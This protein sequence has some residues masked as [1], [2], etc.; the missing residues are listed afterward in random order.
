MSPVLTGFAS[1]NGLLQLQKLQRFSRILAQNY[2]RAIPLPPPGWKKPPHANPGFLLTDRACPTKKMPESEIRKDRIT[3]FATTILSLPL[4]HCVLESLCYAFISLSFTQ[5]GMSPA[6][7]LRAWI[8][9]TLLSF[10][11]YGGSLPCTRCNCTLLHSGGTLPAC[12]PNCSKW[13]AVLLLPAD[14]NSHF[15]ASLPC[16]RLQFRRGFCKQTIIQFQFYNVSGCSR[17]RSSG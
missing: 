5:Y 3:Y 13:A 4:C 17:A 16:S 8:V 9:L 6:A 11:I 1:K 15:S 10:R 14:T 12:R 2:R 7:N